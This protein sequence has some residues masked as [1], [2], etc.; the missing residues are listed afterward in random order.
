MTNANSPARTS[1]RRQRARRF[2]FFVVPVLALC[3]VWAAVELRA[4]HTRDELVA[5][6]EANGG[7]VLIPSESTLDCGFLYSFNSEPKEPCWFRKLLG[8][9]GVSTIMFYAPLPLVRQKELVDS[10]P[11]AFL[12]WWVPGE[13][14]H[15]IN[16]PS[17]KWADQ[18]SAVTINEDAAD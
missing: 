2:A 4:I 1:S 16:D 8:D 6:C 13:D 15:V 9:R 14:I 18:Q 5:W 11:D 3:V 17:G 10:F 7:E 12:A